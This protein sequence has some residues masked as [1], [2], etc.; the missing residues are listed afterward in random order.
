MTS[1]IEAIEVL[2]TRPW[3]VRLIRQVICSDLQVVLWPEL[4]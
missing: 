3:R 1:A 2:D 4:W